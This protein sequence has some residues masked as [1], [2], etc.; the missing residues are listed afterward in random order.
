VNVTFNP[1]VAG[2]ITGALTFNDGTATSPQLVTLSGTGVIPLSF[3]P[4]SL[5]LGTVAVGH[6]AS[7]TVTVTNNEST[8]ISLSSS[9]S[10][11]F[12]I[13]GGTCGSSLGRAPVAPSR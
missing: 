11:D 7:K 8:A 2:A 12:S 3:N 1:S 4:T 9:A 10:A 6:T 5:N 13:T